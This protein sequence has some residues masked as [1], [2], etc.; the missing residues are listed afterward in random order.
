MNKDIRQDV[1]KYWQEKEKEIGEEIRGKDMSEYLGGYNDLEQKTWGLLYFT[2]TSFYFQT[3]PKKSWWSSLLGG[4][5]NE[6]IGEAMKFQILW[7]SVKEI[8]LPSKKKSF[9]SILSPPDYRIFIRYQQDHKDKTLILTIY[10]RSTQ[11]KF[12]ECYQKFH[13]KF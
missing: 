11:E 8:N 1:V 2:D 13:H 4:G 5:Q 10:S 9:L 3:F 7:D 12:L 6:N